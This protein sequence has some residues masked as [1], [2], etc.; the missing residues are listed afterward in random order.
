MRIVAFALG[1][2]SDSGSELGADLGQRLGLADQHRVEDWP[3]RSR[4]VQGALTELCLL[5][6]L[7]SGLED[8][9]MAGLTCP[10]TP[11]R[12]ASSWPIRSVLS[13]SGIPSSSIQVWWRCA[14]V[15]N[16]DAVQ[17]PRPCPE[18]PSFPALLP[19]IV[20]LLTDVSV[21]D[22]PRECLLYDFKGGPLRVPPRDLPYIGQ[23]L[24]MAG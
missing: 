22:N 14:R 13:T 7:Q 24:I 20:S 5:V 15:R 1:E 2:M 23:L 3:Y 19:Q 9:R 6:L 8:A 21:T 10:E 18:A 4:A 16:E 17:P 11:S 12:S